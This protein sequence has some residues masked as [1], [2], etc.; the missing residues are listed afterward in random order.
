VDLTFNRY[1][2]TR[3]APTPSG[4]LH[5]G[6]VLSFAITA[7]LAKKTGAKILLRI[8]D[9][10]QARVND[11]YVTD[12]FETLHFLNIPWQE[13][14]MNLKEF[15]DLYSQTH[16][17]DMYNNALAQLSEGGLVYAC[18]CTRSELNKPGFECPCKNKNIPL[19]SKEVAWR[20]FTQ[21][22]TPIDLMDISGNYQ[23]CVLPADMNNFIVRKKDG[24][25]AYQLT[26]VVDD[27]FYG[28][29]LIVRGE[30]LL[31]STLAQQVLA[32]MMGKSAFSEIAFYHHPLLKSADGEKLS[33]SAGAT[34]VQYLSQ[35]GFKSEDIYQ[36][37]ASMA[38]IKTKVA[39]YEQLAEQLIAL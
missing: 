34:S 16:R 5:L 15:K 12:I 21:D 22:D 28:V 17:L 32:K 3:V 11:A 14:P 7:Y 18:A 25:P 35:Q 19:Q 33:K 29:D 13:G 38:G 4:F 8:D 24:F 1:T 36:S 30:D 2:K 23:N 6:N 39:N 26:S 10:D 20:L 27:L 9:L 31:A 37:I